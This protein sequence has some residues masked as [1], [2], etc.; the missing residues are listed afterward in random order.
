MYQHQYTE[1]LC[2]GPLILLLCISLLKR[3]QGLLTFYSMTFFKIFYG[4]LRK[5]S[6]LT[7]FQG[8]AIQLMTSF[9]V[10]WIVT[11]RFRVDSW[12]SWGL[13]CECWW[14]DCNTIMWKAHC[15]SWMLLNVIKNFFPNT[16]RYLNY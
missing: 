2:I 8:S 4:D 15:N 10:I 14:W 16:A 3:V 12:V 11:L 9:I 5:D 7:A 6:A 1:C 13:V